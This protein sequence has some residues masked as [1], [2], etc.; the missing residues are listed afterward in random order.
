MNAQEMKEKYYELSEYMAQ[1]KDPKNM[2]LF[3]DVLTSMFMWAS[4]AKPEM[5]HEWLGVLEGVLWKQYLSQK[6]AQKIVDGM[7]PKAPWP[8][9]TWKQAM[10]QLGLPLEEEPCYNRFALWCEMNKQYSDQGE[11]V[12][13]LLGMPLTQIPADKIVPAMYKMALNLLKDKDKVYNI[14]SYFGL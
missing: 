7:N 14:R 9:D 10:N 1:S 13:E 4:D 3:G 8:Y 5:A 11:T 2:K 12:A 6:E